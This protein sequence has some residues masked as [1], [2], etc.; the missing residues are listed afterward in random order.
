MA[1]KRGA[2]LTIWL[3]LMLIVNFFTAVTY[4]LLTKTIAASYPNAPSWIWSIYGLLALANF[5]FVIFLFM[6]K[7]W[8][9]FAFCGS[10]VAA[11]IMNLVIS[12]GVL[13]VIMS[14]VGLIMGPLILYLSMKSRW[15]M[16][17]WLF[18]FCRIISRTFFLFLGI[19]Q[20]H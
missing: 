9:F 19:H 16:F 4:L 15:D 1:K 8:P 13:M 12:T 11:F 2:W 20:S 18:L 17:E 3:V 7:K 10:A 14:F 5:V 6:W